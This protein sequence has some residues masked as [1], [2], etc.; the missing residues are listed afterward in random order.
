[1]AS[2]ELLR[3][4]MSRPLVAKAAMDQTPIPEDFVASQIAIDFQVDS[5]KFDF[6]VF[7]SEHLEAED[8]DG[9]GLKGEFKETKISEGT[10]S[11]SL[12]ERGRKAMI[13]RNELAAAR[14][15]ER[16]ARAGG[17]SSAVFDLKV[18][19]ASVLR[20]QH[21]RRSEILKLKKIATA[22]NYKTSHVAGGV[23]SPIAAAINVR[24]DAQIREKLMLANQ[25]IMDDTGF[26]ANTAL[27]GR[28]ARFGLDL[29][30]TVRDAL[31]SDQAKLVTAEFLKLYLGFSNVLFSTALSKKNA[32]AKALP[33]FD[34]FIWI[35]YVDPTENGGG[36]TF[37]RNFWMAYE[38]GGRADSNELVIGV[39]GNTWL[40]Y[41][42]QETAQ[43]VGKDYGFL[44]PTV[45]EEAP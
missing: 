41:A 26:S 18:R 42:E 45:N 20:A 19:V 14:A 10:D 6:P 13:A 11:A 17:S 21:L 25:A 28:G 31:A 5:F 7:G 4:Q 23:G 30:A 33:I 8:D 34:N 39:E 27:V 37:M 2:S 1:M 16:M 32:K 43:I 24:T 3:R 9:V 35:G 22:A 38:G 40:S 36:P 12:F 29:N 44:I 15:A